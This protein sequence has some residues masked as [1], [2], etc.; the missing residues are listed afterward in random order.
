[1]RTA[2]FT[3]LLLENLIG[4]S[5]VCI[6]TDPFHL[7]ATGAASG[8]LGRLAVLLVMIGG[9]GQ[10]DRLQ[11]FLRDGAKREG[12]GGRYLHA[13]VKVYGDRVK[14]RMPAGH[15]RNFIMGVDIDFLSE[16]L[17]EPL[18]NVVSTRSSVLDAVVVQG[19]KRWLYHWQAA[20]RIILEKDLDKFA[21]GMRLLTKHLHL[22]AAF[23]A[24]IFG[25]KSITPQQ[26]VAINHAAFF[27]FKMLRRGRTLLELSM[28]ALEDT[29][30]QCTKLFART[31]AGSQGDRSETALRELMMLLHR[32]K[33]IV[34][35]VKSRCSNT[36]YEARY[37][38]CMTRIRAA[39]KVGALFYL[40]PLPSHSHSHPPHIILLLTLPLGMI[41]R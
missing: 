21:S 8:I 17:L 26:L 20:Y 3:A 39:L 18:T 38:A 16:E 24:A 30:W 1:M 22:A 34:E 36:V 9:V 40:H 10:A 25:P 19:L 32:Q 14:A 23:Q 5:F 37:T 31:K 33:A 4:L 29:H 6:L 41:I 27:G 2:A 15:C 13:K 28:E 35:K 7:V 11:S 12:D